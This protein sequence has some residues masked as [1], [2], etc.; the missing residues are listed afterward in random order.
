MSIG[1]ST[2]PVGS[3]AL[4]RCLTQ[5]GPGCL[6][7]CALASVDSLRAVTSVALDAR[8]WVETPNEYDRMAIARLG[9]VHSVP[10]PLNDNLRPLHRH[11]TPTRTDRS[12]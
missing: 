2:Q 8:R 7:S 10:P 1:P 4:D 6:V 12:G 11:N 9:S 5:D 3:R